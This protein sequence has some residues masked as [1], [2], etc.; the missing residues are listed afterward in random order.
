[1]GSRADKQAELA[2][3]ILLALGAVL[4]DAGWHSVSGRGEWFF[5][6]VLSFALAV[7]VPVTYF[8]LHPLFVALSR[9]RTSFLTRESAAPRR[10]PRK[11]RQARLAE[12]H[13]DPESSGL[14]IL[15]AQYMASDG[16]GPPV[17][18]DVENRVR[19][20]VVNNKLAITV[21]NAQFGGDPW[22]NIPKIL[23]VRYLFN[24]VEGIKTFKEGEVAVLP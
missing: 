20:L 2:T 24:G 5:F 14:E 23:E 9:W 13:N 4:A 18:W 22:L 17:A 6:S 10:Y 1:M 8:G 12:R 7:F 19:E 3:L 11:K 15:G 21:D 16:H